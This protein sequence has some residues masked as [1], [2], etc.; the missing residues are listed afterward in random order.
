M[1]LVFEDIDVTASLGLLTNGI[2]LLA[3]HGL[4]D[5]TGSGEFLERLELGEY[6]VVGTT[7]HYFATPTPGA[8]NGR[9]GAWPPGA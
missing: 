4:N 2:N 3:I 5:T 1:A 6:K 8:P 7:N 9:G